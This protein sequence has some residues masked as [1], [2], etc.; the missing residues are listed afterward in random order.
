M[1]SA[2]DSRNEK[3][4]RRR[5]EETRSSILSQLASGPKAARELAGS[6]EAKSNCLA[7]LQVAGIIKYVSGKWSK[8]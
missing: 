8:I 5:A 7:E 2:Q 3:Y 4:N 1:K 6:K